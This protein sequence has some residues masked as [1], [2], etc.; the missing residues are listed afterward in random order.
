LTGLAAI[1]FKFTAEDYSDHNRFYRRILDVGLKASDLIN[2]EGIIVYPEDIGTFLVLQGV[3]VGDKKLEDAMKHVVIRNLPKL[4]LIKLINRSI[5]P[6]TIILWKN[7]EILKTYERTFEEVAK[8]TGCYIV[9][10]SLLCKYRGKVRNIS[11]TYNPEGEVIGIQ[12]K[13]HLTDLEKNLGIHPSPLNWIKPF[14]TSFGKIGVTICYDGFFDDV[15]SRLR[16]MGAEILIQP[17]ANPEPW[18][19]V[20]DVWFTGC[21][22]MVGKYDFK[23]GAN[24]MGVG[25]ILGLLFEGVSN[26][27]KKNKFLAKADKVDEELI[28][29]YNFKK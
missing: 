14:D 18:S 23:Y 13:V 3:K 1:Q 17:S 11:Y 22:T 4:L 28:I 9:A 21:Y 15:V 6:E 19:K 27:C 20:K 2:N 5:W 12:S 10:G 26:I 7:K 16:E 25:R 8:K 24:P 29:H